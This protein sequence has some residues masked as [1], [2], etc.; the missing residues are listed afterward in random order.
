MERKSELTLTFLSLHASQLGSFLRWRYALFCAFK[1]DED[2]CEGE[3]P[4]DDS[5]GPSLRCDSWKLPDA[6]LGLLEAA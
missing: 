4:A 1:A 3:T 5:E 6:V 2:I